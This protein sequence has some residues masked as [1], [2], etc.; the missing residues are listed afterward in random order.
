MHLKKS[1]LALI[2]SITINQSFSQL[3]LEGIVVE[4]YYISNSA[5]SIDAANNGAVH[6]L[7]IG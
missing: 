2:L 4:K 1:I 3:G 7:H 6:P 5:D